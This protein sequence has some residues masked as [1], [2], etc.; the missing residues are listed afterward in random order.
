MRR[1]VRNTTPNY[2]H[3]DKVSSSQP[4]EAG[5]TGHVGH[6]VIFA[7]HLE[8]LKVI[9]MDILEELRANA[10]FKNHAGRRRHASRAGFPGSCWV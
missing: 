7:D 9:R 3:R 4:R 2:L 8:V 6:G 5:S 1:W 10:P